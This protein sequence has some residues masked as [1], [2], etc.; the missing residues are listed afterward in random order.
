ME[1]GNNQLHGRRATE[2]AVGTLMIKCPNTGMEISTGMMADGPSFA[3]TPVFFSRTYCP[4]CRVNHDWFAT[5]AWVCEHNFSEK[6][7]VPGPT[8]RTS[9]LAAW[10][11]RVQS[12]GSR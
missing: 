1:T 11:M 8:V 7:E 9:V 3:A 6:S 12:R 10:A 2:A 4:V 5:D